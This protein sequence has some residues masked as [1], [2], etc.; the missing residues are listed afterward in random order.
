MI[1]SSLLSCVVKIQSAE[2][3]LFSTNLLY[4]AN[5]RQ[6]R[7]RHTGSWLPLVSPTPFTGPLFRDEPGPR[8]KPLAALAFSFFHKQHG[9]VAGSC[10]LVPRRLLNAQHANTQDRW[11]EKGAKR[12][13]STRSC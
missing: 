12:C 11:A 2:E 9:L 8:R 6:W 3:P 1:P 7:E 5:L 4:H 13:W 10:G